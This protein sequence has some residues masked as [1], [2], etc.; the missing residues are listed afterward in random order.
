MVKATSPRQT[1]T[2]DDLIL[3]K[4]AL[5]EHGYL[6]PIPRVQLPSGLTEPLDKPAPRH[7]MLEL[8]RAR[9]QL[10]M[11]ELDKLTGKRSRGA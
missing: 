11:K 6:K 8:K 7:L 4:E 3:A 9:L 2:K 5:R 10:A 1:I